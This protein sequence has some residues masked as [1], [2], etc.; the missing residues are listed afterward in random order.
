MQSDNNNLLKIRKLKVKN[1]RCF[2]E[3]EFEFD[4]EFTV[5]VGDNG[6]GKTA[7]LDGLASA[8]SCLM[9]VF[10]RGEQEEQVPFDSLDARLVSAPTAALPR[11][12]PQYPVEVCC[13]GAMGDTEVSW[14]RDVPEGRREWPFLHDYSSKLLDLRDQPVWP[15]IAYYGS[16]RFVERAGPV[17]ELVG[18]RPRSHGYAGCLNATASEKWFLTWF[19]TLELTGIQ[20]GIPV[21]V[22]AGVKRVVVDCL[23]YCDDVVWAT[24]D[25]QL[26]VTLKGRH[27]LP[28]R[29]LSSGQRIMLSLVADMASRASYLN[30][31]FE[32][33][34]AAETPGVVLIDDVDLHLHPKWQRTVVEK[35]RRTFPKVQFIATTHSP[36]I[37]QSLREGELL[38][39]DEAEHGEYAGKSIED[40][41]ENV[42]GVELPQRSERYRRMMAAAERYY[43]V[44]QRAKGAS[45]EEQERLKAELD[46]LAAPFSDDVAYQAFLKMER[47]AAGLE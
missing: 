45:A 9:W 30:P 15:L 18:Q 43:R 46:E 7:V 38:V 39:L 47:I 44:L 4:D 24:R 23:G 11:L 28:F 36:F 6:A 40:V 20:E 26:L 25:D 2:E 14:G 1:F 33:H 16:G 37:I 32:E 42:M 17:D 13:H 19:R 34:A 8:L 3:R 21:P 12:E 10:H 29:A 22:L 41:V 27:G 31:Q 5:L 35:L